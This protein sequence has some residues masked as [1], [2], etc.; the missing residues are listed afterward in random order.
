MTLFDIY[1][2]HPASV[3]YTTHGKFELIH[4]TTGDCLEPLACKTCKFYTD[5]HVDTC[6][7]PTKSEHY[8]P[9]YDYFKLHH[10]EKLL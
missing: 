3:I 10:P 2:Q 6:Y 8:Q 4:A 7:L 9:T 1:T 5:L